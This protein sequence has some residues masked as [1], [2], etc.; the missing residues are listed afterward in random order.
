MIWYQCLVCGYNEMPK[1]PRDYNICPCCGVEY[2]L[3]NAFED[4]RSLRDEWLTNGG[5]WFSRHPQQKAPG[6]WNAWDQLDLADYEYSIPRHRSSSA[7]R[8][9]S[10]RLL[11]KVSDRPG[12]LTH[13]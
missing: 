1:P 2:D 4:F 6:N 13:A 5:H 7:L 3:D 12:R 11:G 10:V 9:S 8:I